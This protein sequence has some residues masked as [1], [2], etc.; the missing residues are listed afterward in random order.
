MCPL[1]PASTHYRHFSKKLVYYCTSVL[2]KVL[3]TFSCRAFLW[4]TYFQ[5][6]AFLWNTYFQMSSYKCQTNMKWCFYLCC[7]TL[8]REAG[9]ENK[10][11]DLNLG[12][13]S[14]Q[15][16]VSSVCL[17]SPEVLT[18]S[19]GEDYLKA[20][21]SSLCCF[22]YPHDPFTKLQDLQLCYRSTVGCN[23]NF[24]TWSLNLQWSK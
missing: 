20:A 3:I 13:R 24:I 16:N 22:I 5:M 9:L 14:W 15:G 11:S 21:H 19:F 4:S 10:R 6:R 17:F 23:E 2:P 18:E 7:C 8:L 12:S 1:D